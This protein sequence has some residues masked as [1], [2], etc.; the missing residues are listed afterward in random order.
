MVSGEIS[1]SAGELATR[2]PQLNRFRPAK[3]VHEYH[4]IFQ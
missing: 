3:F 2:R 1:R 4:E